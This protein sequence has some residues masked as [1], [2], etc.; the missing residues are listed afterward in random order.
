MK[1]GVL[2]LS[3]MAIFFGGLRFGTKAT[4]S[5]PRPEGAAVSYE[6]NY[7]NRREKTLSGRALSKRSRS[8]SSP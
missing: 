8:T 4:G 3:L 6:F 1:T 7:S 5:N 2:I